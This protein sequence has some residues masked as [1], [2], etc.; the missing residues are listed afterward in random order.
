MSLDDDCD[1]GVATILGRFPGPVIVRAPMF[2][3]IGALITVTLFSGVV[4]WRVW[5]LDHW[6]LQQT[7]LIGVVALVCA[8]AEI[9]AILAMFDE[10]NFMTLDADGF[11]IQFPWGRR[12]RSW[13]EVD[14]F[15]ARWVGIGGRV[16]AFN[17]RTD[18]VIVSAGL[19]QF[20]AGHDGVVSYSFG[21]TKDDFARL[22]N[23]WRERALALSR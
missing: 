18:A 1:D 12:R 11:Q 5:S 2:K 4:A 3:R 21:F 20:F 16:L 15:E 13:R 8:V 7:I 14:G 23:E 19:N 17:Y 22:M 9:L 10:L 6:S